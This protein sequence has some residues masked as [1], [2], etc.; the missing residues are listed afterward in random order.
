[1]LSLYILAHSGFSKRCCPI[2]ESHL[3]WALRV[4]QPGGGCSLSMWVFFLVLMGT[5][6]FIR[7]NWVIIQESA[8]S[9][10]GS[11]RIYVSQKLSS[12]LPKS[13]EVRRHYISYSHFL[14]IVLILIIIFIIRCYHHSLLMKFVCNLYYI[15]LFADIF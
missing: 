11:H 4:L 7:S 15:A 14:I 3:F 2:A 8:L 13:M 12:R 10:S 1:M 5:C 9:E 6:C